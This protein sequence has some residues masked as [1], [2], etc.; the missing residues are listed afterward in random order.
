MAFGIEIAGFEWDESKRAANLAK[1]GMDF[2]HAARLLSG[3]HLAIVSWH[4]GEE[5]VQAICLDKEEFVTVVYTMHGRQCRIISA[6]RSHR[7]ERRQY[8]H[9]YD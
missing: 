1:H 9:I 7:S 8:R 4:R 2:M 5:R 3:P 6:R